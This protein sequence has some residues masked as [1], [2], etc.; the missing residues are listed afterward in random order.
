MRR[1]TVSKVEKNVAACANFLKKGVCDPWIVKA[2]EMKKAPAASP[3]HGQFLKADTICGRCPHFS[4][5]I[6]FEWKWQA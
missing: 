4:E 3:D 1:K 5:E 6:F 2:F